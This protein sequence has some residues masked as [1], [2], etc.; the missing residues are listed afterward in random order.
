[1]SSPSFHWEMLREDAEL[2]LERHAS[3]TCYLTRYNAATDKFYLSVKKTEEGKEGCT[4]ATYYHFLLRILNKSSSPPDSPP[5][6]FELHEEKDSEPEYELKG[7][8]KKFDTISELLTFY[9]SIPINFVVTTIGDEVKSDFI[10][11]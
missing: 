9:R 7:T 1:M 6:D 10:V 8:E 2:K 4:A 3:P 5:Y 11:S